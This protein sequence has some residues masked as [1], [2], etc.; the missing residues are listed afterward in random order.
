MRLLYCHNYRRLFLLLFIS[1]ISNFAGCS[2]HDNDYIPYMLKGL[3]VWVYN[4]TNDKEYYGG[5][6][7]A[8]YFS[9]DNALSECNSRAYAVAN[10]YHLTDWSYICC[11]VT[12][13]SDCVTKVR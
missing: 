7:K 6:V 12:S 8:N 10:Q 4:N 1:L 2:G 5:R 13:S 9:R 11:T 3:D